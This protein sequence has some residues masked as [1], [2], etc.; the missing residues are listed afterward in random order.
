VYALTLR[1]LAILLEGARWQHKAQR[2]LAITQA[3]YSSWLP[4]QKRIPTL[5]SLL[6]ERDKGPAVTP[7]AQRQFFYDFAQRSGLTVEVHETPVLTYPAI[8]GQVTR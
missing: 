5:E 7:E 8:P 4:R 3:W 1:E 6:K 2:A